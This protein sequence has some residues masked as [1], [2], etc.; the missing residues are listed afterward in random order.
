[1]SI[2]WSSYVDE[3]E[4]LNLHVIA[5]PT[6]FLAT[7]HDLIPAMHKRAIVGDVT[8]L[9]FLR[10]TERKAI[11][12]LLEHILNECV[13]HNY[14]YFNDKSKT[15]NRVHKIRFESDGMLN[16]NNQMYVNPDLF[17]VVHKML[18]QVY[19]SPESYQ[20]AYCFCLDPNWEGQEANGKMHKM[21]KLIGGL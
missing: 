7:I 2:D 16:E 10:E 6:A 11:R 4:E 9:V 15:P 3:S 13:A 12:A 17:E 19:E 21:R 8:V 18:S 14:A 20:L 1:M 5:L